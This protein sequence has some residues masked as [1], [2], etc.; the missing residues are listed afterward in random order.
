MKPKLIKFKDEVTYKFGDTRLKV[1][2]DGVSSDAEHMSL[3][4]IIFPPGT[5]TQDHS[6]TVEEIIYVTKGKA[7]VA[8]EDEKY[9]LNV[10]DSI[11]IPPGLI[12]R[13]ENP[14]GE[15]L[16]QIWIFA[17]SGPEKP[18]RELEKVSD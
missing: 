8:T 1:L 15:P 18:L 9:E 5:K 3:G 10:G 11:Y 16:E 12:H 4:W 14:F 17:P 6:R 13:H 7:I 2:I